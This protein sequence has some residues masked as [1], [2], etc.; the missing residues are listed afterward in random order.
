MSL[1]DTMMPLFE[2]S[3]QYSNVVF[4]KTI[5]V[6]SSHYPLLTVEMEVQ[7]PAIIAHYVLEHGSDPIKKLE[8]D[9]EDE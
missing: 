9:L 4:K 3:K 8:W 6:E 7:D 5:D 1:N 2:W